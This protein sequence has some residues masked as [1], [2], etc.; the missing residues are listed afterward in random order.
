M[1]AILNKRFNRGFTLIELL[2]VVS[3]IAILAS[4]LLPALSKAREK[5]RRTS[6][7]NNLKQIGL[8]MQL[9]GDDG[10]GYGLGKGHWVWDIPK[11]SIMVRWQEREYFMLGSL[12]EGS[13]LPA[14]KTFYC[15]SSGKPPQDLSIRNQDRSADYSVWH[16]VPA[17]NWDN[18]G[19][20]ITPDKDRLRLEA[21]PEDMPVVTDRFTTVGG[22]V[23]VALKPMYHTNY[24]MNF[25]YA[26][27]HAKGYV[28]TDQSI[29]T[30][31]SQLSYRSQA[32]AAW[33]AALKE[34]SQ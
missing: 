18:T 16:R 12:Y 1:K 28:D 30:L 21:M 7:L 3:I 31:A 33:E 11:S 27:G 25:S 20:A 34:A 29:A 5:S 23:N 22:T 8:G 15:P 14:S 24:Y 13:Y 10:D 17:L 32:N 6:C 9:Y 4:L 26:D 2:V 19:G